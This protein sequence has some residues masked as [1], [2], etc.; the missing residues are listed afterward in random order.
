MNLRKIAKR[1]HKGL[2]KLQ[3]LQ[4]DI[5]RNIL[6][7]PEEKKFGCI[8]YFLMFLSFMNYD[9]LLIHNKI[10]IVQ[11]PRLRQ[12]FFPGQD[13]SL[14]KLRQEEMNLEGVIVTPLSPIW[15]L[16]S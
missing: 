3:N 16:N 7:L 14:G 15:L 6:V 5:F 9:H 2:G 10:K 11:D 4:V 1:K 13:L 12:T 8:P